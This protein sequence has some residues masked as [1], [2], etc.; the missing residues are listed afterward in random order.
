[1]CAIITGAFVSILWPKYIMLFYVDD[2][3]Y[4]GLSLEREQAGA[5]KGT[6]CLE[7][8]VTVRMLVMYAV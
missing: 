8:I 1:M 4:C 2:Y 7:H 3:N 5:Q 6:C